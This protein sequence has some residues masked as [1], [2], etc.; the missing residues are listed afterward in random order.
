MCTPDKKDVLHP[1]A[2]SHCFLVPALEFTW[3]PNCKFFARFSVQLDQFLELVYCATTQVLVPT[4]RRLWK[5]VVRFKVKWKNSL[6]EEDLG[7]KWQLTLLRCL[8]GE[9][10]FEVEQFIMSSCTSK[11]VYNISTELLT[12]LIVKHKL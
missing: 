1:V 6:H 7:K 11:L 8:F 12:Y 3:P 2:F 10:K 5:P 4:K 9:A